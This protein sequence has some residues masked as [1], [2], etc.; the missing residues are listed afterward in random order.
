MLKILASTL[1]GIIGGSML[2]PF[3]ILKLK[4][5]NYTESSIGFFAS[6][7]WIGLLLASPYVA[8]IT[9]IF[10]YRRIYI[11]TGIVSVAYVLTLFYA[12]NYYVWCVV[13]F[14]IGFVWA[15]RWVTT[16]A[17]INAIAPAD[18]RGKFIGIYG[19]LV[20][21]ALAIGPSILLMTGTN[22][23]MP[24]YVALALFFVSFFLNFLVQ[25]IKDVYDTESESSLKM[26]SFFKAHGFFFIA[27]FFGGV[28]ENGI[29]PVSVLYA[30]SVGISAENAALVA[31]AIGV[32]ALLVQYPIGWMADKYKGRNHYFTLSI[33]LLAANSLLLLAP[34]YGFVVYIA[35]FFWG[36]FGPAMYVL[37]VTKLGGIYR[38]NDLVAVTSF[39]IF[40][41]TMGGIMAP[42][43][44]GATIELSGVYGL[45]V[46]LLAI[47]AFI[48]I[49][50]KT[51]SAKYKID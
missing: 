30:I 15:T 11:F 39:V 6:L 35:A 23:D 32:G 24:F 51:A 33:L 28:F 27:A 4:G 41:Y 16:E 36:V 17:F 2:I 34:Q 9:A 25:D 7:S 21:I 10:G 14:L 45:P 5:M 38:Q 18:K 19:S 42:L 44:G 1:C 26:V 20:W 13:H 48:A 12:Q 37:I 50:A 29:T 46:L 22:S 43:V 3:L 40:G 49:S 47:S 31:S 8:R